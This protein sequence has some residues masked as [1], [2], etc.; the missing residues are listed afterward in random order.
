M[1][2]VILDYFLPEN[3]EENELKLEILDEAGK[4]VRTY[5]NQ[6][7][8]DF[9]KYPGGPS[10]QKVLSTKKGVNRFAW[11]MRSHPTPA[12]K[13]VFVNGTY[14][15]A[16]VVP[17]TYQLKLT[18]GE[19]VST[20]TA[21]IIPDPRLSATPADYTAQ[22]GLLMQIDDAVIDIHETVNKMRKVKKQVTNYKTL[23]KEV[24]GVDTLL[25]QGTAIVEK[26]ETLENS[27]IQPKQKT[28]QDVINFPNQLNS[29]FMNLKGKI[30][31]HDPQLTEG[32]QIRFNDLMKEWAT[33]KKSYQEI[34]D[35][36]IAKFNELY[37]TLKVP[38]LVIPEE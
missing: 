19:N 12:V 34:L 33:A 7:D 21:T 10:P 22:Q 3:M 23:L 15:G 8:K 16:M 6:K 32:V 4:L 31:S 25:H 5:T 30:D 27:L 18:A 14:N 2:G 28:F 35:I 29:H 24:E 9:K 37:R 11:D 26:I 17:G 13:G 1:N 38:A 20:A 36:D